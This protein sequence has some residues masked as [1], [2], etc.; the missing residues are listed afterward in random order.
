[1]TNRRDHYDQDGHYTGYS[2]DSYLSHQ[3]D[4][5]EG[6][7]VG[8]YFYSNAD[9]RARDAATIKAKNA[10]RDKANRPAV[11]K[12]LAFS[13][14]IFTITFLVGLD[15]SDSWVIYVILIPTFLTVLACIY[16]L[17]KT[18]NL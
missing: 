8:G 7:S 9:N 16:S 3:Y 15:N 14:V 5:E 2:E 11:K 17:L 12:W 1:V 18:R 10:A 4:L 6:Q 13:L